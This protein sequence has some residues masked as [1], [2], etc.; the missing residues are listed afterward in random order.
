[1][2]GHRI[3]MESAVRKTSG[4]I[5]FEKRNH[6][7]FDGK[8]VKTWFL[9]VCYPFVV[10][11]TRGESISVTASADTTLH[12]LNPTFNMGGESYFSMGATAKDTRARALIKFDLKQVALP[13]HSVITNVTIHF[14]LPSLNRPDTTAVD[15]EFYL[16]NVSWGEGTKLGNTGSSATAGEATW[17]QRSVPTSWTAPGAGQ[18]SDYEPFPSGHGNLGPATGQYTIPS[19]L[20]LIRDVQ[21]WIAQPERNF[22]WLGKA[23]DESVIQSAKRFSSRESGNPAVLQIDYTILDDIVITHHEHRSGGLFF[24]WSGGMPPYQVVASTNLTTGI[25]NPITTAIDGNEAFFGAMLDQ[26]YFRVRELR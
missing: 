11:C 3:E 21:L 4:S 7:K 15:Y 12:E 14:N 20:G 17:N 25:W 9:M 2:G 18:G 19:T 23:V 5:R 24:Q 6:L 1:M 10:L 26:N 22:G 16:V 13:A 8:H